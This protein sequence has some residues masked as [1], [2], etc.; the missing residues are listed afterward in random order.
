MASEAN[1][2]PVLPPLQRSEIW[3]KALQNSPWMSPPSQLSSLYA[4]HTLRKLRNV[5][6]W[7]WFSSLYWAGGGEHSLPPSTKKSENSFSASV[8]C[9]FPSSFMSSGWEKQPSPQRPPLLETLILPEICAPKVASPP[10]VIPYA[11]QLPSQETW[12]ICKVPA[13]GKLVSDNWANQSRY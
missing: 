10:T 6:Y 11:L 4:F 3:G 8:G 7:S 12:W 5:K 9:S 1:V 13:N 2:P